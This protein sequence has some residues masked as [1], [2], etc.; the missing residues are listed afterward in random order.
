MM[1]TEHLEAELMG[2][3]ESING[4]LDRIGQIDPVLEQMLAEIQAQSTRSPVIGLLNQIQWKS[5]RISRYLSGRTPYTPARV[6]ERGYSTSSAIRLRN[7]VQGMAGWSLY[8][9]RTPLPIMQNQQGITIELN[10]LLTGE[11]KLRMI[12]GL[13][14]EPWLQEEIDQHIHH[15]PIS[16]LLTGVT[17]RDD[18]NTA[19]QLLPSDEPF[20]FQPPQWS[21]LGALYFMPIIPAEARKIVLSIQGV[22]IAQPFVVTA[23]MS[24][25][26]FKEGPWLF[27]WEPS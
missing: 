7:R 25:I 18:R 9:T 22:L 8:K 24:P 1:N 23:T 4:E 15:S 14:L 2:V 16:V 27:E 11:G 5:G 6:T 20:L 13:R 19:Y 17:L 21:C 26:Y 12:G 3:L 10:H